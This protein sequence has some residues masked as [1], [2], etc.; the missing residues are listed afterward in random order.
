MPNISEE[1]INNDNIQINDIERLIEDQIKESLIL[2]YKSGD[3]IQDNKN[4]KFNLKKWVSSFA[5]SAGGT[6]I[7]GVS[8]KEIDNECYPDKIDGIDITKFK[9]DIGKWIDDVLVDNIYPRLNPPPHIS[10]FRNKDNKTLAVIR[11]KPTNFYIHKV[12]K[13]SNY[14]YFHRH[15]FQV[16]S[17][18]EWEIRTL[19][20]GRTP[21]PILEPT[22]EQIFVGHRSGDI[23]KGYNIKIKIENIGWR[24]AKYLQ[25]G[26]IRPSL[27][28]ESNFRANPTA[29]KNR[30]IYIPDGLKYIFDVDDDQD[31]VNDSIGFP[32]ANYLHPYD[33]IEITY[34][35]ENMKRFPKYD[36]FYVGFYIFAENLLKPECYE[37]KIECLGDDDKP[38]Y[39]LRQFDGQ[40]IKVLAH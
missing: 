12:I 19:V 27:D 28:L 36:V 39:E 25:F 24:I 3:W 26:I 6:I 7:I 1:L 20:L 8:E 4:S 33:S 22:I 9:E 13:G 38:K 11:I 23:I 34:Q 35:L 16:L 40:K 31:I 2:E 32:E 29:K 17:M 37:I 5:N 30:K 18:D 21:P 15:N 10:T 14:F